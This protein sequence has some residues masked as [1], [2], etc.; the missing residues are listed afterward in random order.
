MQIIGASYIFLCNQ[1]FEILKNAGIAFDSRIVAIG[2]YEDLRSTYADASCDFYEGSVILPTFANPHIHFEFSANKTSFAYGGFDRWLD[3]VIANRDEV[4]AH[5]LPAIKEAIS[6]QLK[7]GVGIVGAISSYSDDLEVLAK[8]PLKVVYFNEALGSNPAAIDFLYAHFL[9]R[10]EKS[11]QY[12]SS[13]FKPALAIHSPYSTHYILAKKILEVARERELPVSIHFLESMW[14]RQWL[15]DSSGWFQQFFEETLKVGNPVSLY[16]VGDFLELFDGIKTLFVHALFA[17]SKEWE[18]MCRNGKIITCPRS[19]RLLNNSLLDLDTVGIKHIGI[20]TDGNSSNVN[21]NY[22]D[23]LRTM[24]FS[25]PH[26]DCVRFA[27]D[28]LRMATRNGAEALG[29]EGGVL[30]VGNPSD[31][32]IFPIGEKLKESQEAL[33]FLLYAKEASAV[34]IDGIEVTTKQ[35]Q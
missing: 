27:V 10:F 20:A 14:E 17:E 18:R 2:D 11:M 1:N 24:L 12:K 28:I 21:L 35:W 3:S 9:E 15:E 5:S 19:N 22:L 34:Y 26:Y 30:Q 7:S 16:R 13:R 6:Q 29:V 32:S 4:L 33:Q 8:S 31:F 23:E 25:Y